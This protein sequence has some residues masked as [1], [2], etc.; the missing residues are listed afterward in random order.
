MYQHTT[1]VRVRYGETDQ[2]GYVYYGNYASYYEVARVEA[3][4]HLGMSY[5]KLEES[6]VMMP[7]LEN[8]SYY[9][10]PVLYDDLLTIKVILA[11]M[12][13]VKITFDYE[14]RAEGRALVHSGKTV[15]AFM[16]ADTKRPCRPPQVMLEL[17]KPYFT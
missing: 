11:K 1:Q 15:L 3:L 2:M 14:F 4:R 5:R 10:Q 8:H 9:H 17:L 12:P 13:S 7:V 16:N 6:G